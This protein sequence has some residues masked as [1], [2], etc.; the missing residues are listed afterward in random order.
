[1]INIKDIPTNYYGVPS[2]KEHHKII[3][4]YL[5]STECKSCK[6]KPNE[7]CK[8]LKNGV[9]MG[10]VPDGFDSLVFLVNYFN[11]HPKEFIK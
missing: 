6:A 3:H 4:S 11:E 9:H 8:N 7:E 5:I 10:R 1:M 2:K